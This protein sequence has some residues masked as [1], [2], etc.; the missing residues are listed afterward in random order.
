MDLKLVKKLIDLMEKHRLQEIEV[1][2][3]ETRIYISKGGKEP[4]Q[5]AISPPPLSPLKTEEKKKTKNL[6]SVKAPIVGTFYRAPA[7]GAPPYVN[8]GDMVTPG[9]V[10]CV[11]EA[12]KVMNEIEAEV[13]RKIVKIVAENNKPVEFGQEIFLIEQ[14]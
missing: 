3:G 10:L 12:M 14:S 1:E 4:V 6:I 13:E 8:V 11:I 9:K 5:T 2:E 7:P